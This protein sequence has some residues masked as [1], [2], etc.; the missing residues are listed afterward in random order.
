[1]LSSWAILE[2]K[3]FLAFIEIIDWHTWNIIDEK[4]TCGVVEILAFES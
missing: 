2:N 1:M 4:N 3:I